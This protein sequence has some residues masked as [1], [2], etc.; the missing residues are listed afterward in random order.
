MLSIANP[1]I[2]RTQGLLQ[3]IGAATPD[4]NGPITPD[5]SARLVSGVIEGLTVDGHG[6][7]MYSHKGTQEWL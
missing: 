7:K 6:G 3:K 2:Q 1:N 5:E 4:F